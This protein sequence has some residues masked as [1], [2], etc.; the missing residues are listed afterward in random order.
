M[1][2][3]DGKKILLIGTLG[4]GKTTIARL[5]S[6]ATGFGM[7]SIDD[8]RER[9]GDGTVTGE[10]RAWTCFIGACNDRKPAILEF[11]GGGPHV[12]AVR[13]ALLQSGV[14]I[15]VIWLDPP[16]ETCIKRASNRA[17]EVPTPYPWG[18]IDESATMIYQ[19]IVSAWDGVWTERPEIN[20]VR[21]KLKGTE[22]AAEVF[23]M[24]QGCL[25]DD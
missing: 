5:S 3:N 21:M 13:Q 12:Y 23:K 20:A 17:K 22:R 7:T 14:P 1:V 10:Y 6:N 4:S 11:S 2:E 25:N 24:I 15:H 19:G 18:P 9:F 16:L 8:C